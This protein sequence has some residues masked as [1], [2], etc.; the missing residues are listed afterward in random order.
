MSAR[1]WSAAL[2]FFFVVIVT[3][4]GVQQKT[5]T[6]KQLR[7]NSLQKTITKG[8]QFT[9]A[10]FYKWQKEHEREHRT[11][12]WLRCELGRDKVHVE[13]VYCAVCRKYETNIC[14]FK[15]WGSRGLPTSSSATVVDHARSNVPKAA[16]SRLRADSAREKGESAILSTSLGR[17]LAALDEV[18]Y[19]RVK[20]RC[21]ICYTTAKQSLPFAKYPALLELEAHHGA[22]LGFVYNT[23][24][25]AK[26]FTTYVAKSLW[27]SFLNSPSTSCTIFF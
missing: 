25:S 12:T 3:P 10:T 23:P 26:L 14:V 7:G 11:L 4:R 5:T 2:L 15:L 19:G 24:D 9:K 16:M 22:D 8:R 17:C 1:K 18:S 21:G 6:N 27:Q 13:S 20:L